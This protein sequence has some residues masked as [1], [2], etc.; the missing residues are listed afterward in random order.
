[1]LDLMKCYSTHNKKIV[2]LDKWLNTQDKLRYSKEY[3][4]QI[5]LVRDKIPK[6]KL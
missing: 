1:M 4:K 5:K 2:S 6:T 3:Q